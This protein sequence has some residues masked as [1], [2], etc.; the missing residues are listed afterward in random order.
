MDAYVGFDSAWTDNA[1]APG[2]I[3]AVGVE[4]GHPVQFHKP[5]LAS[6]DQALTFIGTSVPT[7]GTRSSRWTSQPWFP[8]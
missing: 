6:F 5:R 4:G 7:T 3:C 1:K 8:T 2:A